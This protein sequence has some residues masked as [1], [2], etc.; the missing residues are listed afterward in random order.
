M[1]PPQWCW[2]SDVTDK[3]PYYNWQFNAEY[4]SQAL[5]QTTYSD[6]AWLQ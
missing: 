2:R 4:M 5:I 6:G 1:K 3:D